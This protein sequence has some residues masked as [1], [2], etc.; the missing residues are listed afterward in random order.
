MKAANPGIVEKARFGNVSDT[1]ATS[2]ADQAKAVLQANPDITVVFA[3]YDEFARGVKLA[4]ADLGISSKLKIYS[5]DISTA[6]IQ[7][8]TE[9]GSPWV[10]TAADQSGRRRCGLDPSRSPADRRRNR[11]AEGGRRSSSRDPAAAARCRRNHDRRASQKDPGLLHQRGRN[12]I[13]DFRLPPFE[14]IL[15]SMLGAATGR[16]SSRSPPR[17]AS[18]ATTPA[19]S[20]EDVGSL[21]AIRPPQSTELANSPIQVGSLKVPESSLPRV[22]RAWPSGEVLRAAEAPELIT[23]SHRNSF[24]SI[25]RRWLRATKGL[26]TRVVLSAHHLL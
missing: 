13:L 22:L 23:L 2:T 21:G 19:Y 8:I 7:E 25:G 26:R 16:G 9:E 4:A 24:P 20:G 10:A 5:A 18:A 3:P 14:P 11:A 17:K 15:P 6:D 12:R 1:T